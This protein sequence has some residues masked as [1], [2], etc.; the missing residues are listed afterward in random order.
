MSPLPVDEENPHY[1]S[2]NLIFDK[3]AHPQEN[4][5][6]ASKTYAI[7]QEKNEEFNYGMVEE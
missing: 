7:R 2:T 4:D 3:N 1:Y 5:K 6:I